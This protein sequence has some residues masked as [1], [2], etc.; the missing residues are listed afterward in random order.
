M[1]CYRTGLKLLCCSSSFLSTL[2]SGYGR[3]Y[4]PPGGPPPYGG[5]P[6]YDSYGGPYGGRGGPPPNRRGGG[7]GGERRRRDEGPPGV[8]LV[9]LATIVSVEGA[10]VILIVRKYLILGPLPYQYMPKRILAVGEKRR[11]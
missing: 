10:F 3:D 4:G 5:D 2:D 8:S 1:I 9:S 7:G 11:E 6:Y